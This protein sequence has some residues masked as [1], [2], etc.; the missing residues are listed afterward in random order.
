[1]PSSVPEL[2][3]AGEAQGAQAPTQFTCFI[4]ESIN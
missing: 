3:R 1:M 4:A 2:C